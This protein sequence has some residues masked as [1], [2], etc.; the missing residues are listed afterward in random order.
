[1][2]D[3]SCRL[4]GKDELYEICKKE[5]ALP[6]SDGSLDDL[7]QKETACGVSACVITNY[8]G[9]CG[10]DRIIPLYAVSEIHNAEEKIKEIHKLGYRGVCI[11]PN[12]LK[13]P[14][15][16]RRLTPV[17]SAAANLGLAVIVRCGVSHFAEYVYCTPA[18]LC[19]VADAFPDTPF[20]FSH[21]GGCRK[22]EEAAAVLDRKNAYLDTS[23]AAFCISPS[24]LK[25][26]VDVCGAEKILFSSDMPWCTPS[27]ISAFLGFAGIK[28]KDRELIECGNAEK[29]LASLL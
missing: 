7:L 12:E 24:L 5:K 19:A 10:T 17:Y 28:G 13:I 3:F 4:Y 23:S 2:M 26:T 6:Y 11:E 20:I 9:T 29:L 8:G 27:L 21:L 25:E 22:C 1:M 16:D 14:A 18:R 15:D